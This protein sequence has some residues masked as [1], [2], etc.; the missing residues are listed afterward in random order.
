[1]EI[2]KARQEDLPELLAIYNYEVRCGVA[3]LD[4]EEKSLR[5]WQA[6][7]DAHQSADHPIFAA[8][9]DGSVAGYVSLSPYREKEAYKSTAELSIYIAPQYRGRGIA[10]SLM[11]YILAYAK[12]NQTLHTIVSVI[13][14]GNA[15]SSHLH[16]KYGFEFCGTIGEVGMKFGRYLDIDNYRVTV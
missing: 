12:E 13:T 16:E 9:S 3:T 4:L 11:E 10:S 2:R 8:V 6:W 7:F 1:M 15:T 14:S 5:E